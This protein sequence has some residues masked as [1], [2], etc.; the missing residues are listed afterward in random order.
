MVTIRSA[1]FIRGNTIIIHLMSFHFSAAIDGDVFRYEAS[2][3]KD[4]DGCDPS[5]N[6]Y[7]RDDIMYTIQRL[8]SEYLCVEEKEDETGE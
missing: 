6:Q 2:V 5:V 1:A 3:F 4:P 7:R 8:I